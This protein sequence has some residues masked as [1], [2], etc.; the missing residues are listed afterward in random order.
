M[1]MACRSAWREPS[2]RGQRGLSR[3]MGVR[4]WLRA[5]SSGAKA[6]RHDRPHAEARRRPQRYASRTPAGPSL[7]TLAGRDRGTDLAVLRIGRRQEFAPNGWR[8]K[9][10]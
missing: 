1:K 2:K 10:L 5:A 4:M 8:T 3:C 9:H 6:W 7:A